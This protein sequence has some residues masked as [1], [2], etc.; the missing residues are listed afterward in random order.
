MA[1]N[2]DE[3]H[4]MT[5]K[6]VYGLVFFG[7]PN[8]GLRIQHWLPM[9]KDQPNDGVVKSLAPGSEYLLGLQTRFESHFTLPNS[10]ILSIFETMKTPTARR[11]SEKSTVAYLK[12]P[13]QS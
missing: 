4:R 9:V 13:K 6:C 3:R 5:A 10:K 1:V 8:Y 7:V 11:V 2:T 12:T